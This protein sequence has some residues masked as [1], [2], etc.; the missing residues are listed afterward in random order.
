MIE[1]STD[2]SKLQI[3]VIHQFITNAYWA[4][5]RT[6]AEVKKT[7]EHCFCF[8]VYLDDRQIGFA[9]VATDYTVFAYLMDVFILE[10]HRGKGYSKALIA[11]IHEA[12]ELK[13]CKVWM[14]KTAD[15]HGLY[16]QFGYTALMN[17][18]KVM[19]R[20]LK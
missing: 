13:S 11:R 7:I 12:E 2:K 5:G 16:K 15:A 3:D 8:G 9:R 17:P 18:E 10:E 6:V 19:E 14:L 4:K 20:I 1:I